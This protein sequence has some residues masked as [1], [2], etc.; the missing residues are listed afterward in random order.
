MSAENPFSSQRKPAAEVAVES[1]E[2][3]LEGIAD[4]VK[5][6]AEVSLTLRSKA[7]GATTFLK[8]GGSLHGELPYNVAVGSELYLDSMTMGGVGQI[9]EVASKGNGVYSVRTEDGSV[10]ELK[11]ALPEEEASVPTQAPV[12]VEARNIAEPFPT[13]EATRERFP[14]LPKEFEKIVITKTA[15]KEGQTSSVAAGAVYEGILLGD[16]AEGMSLST[17]AVSTGAIERGGITQVGPGEFQI[18][19]STSTYRIKKAS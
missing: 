11:K 4:W 6:R 1:A 17:S 14:E 7:E 16:I 12:P 13:A 18:E 19:T 5:E 10:Y 2:T 8:V 3:P 15:I 9:S